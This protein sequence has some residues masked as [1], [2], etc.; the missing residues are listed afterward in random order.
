[1]F[2]NIKKPVVLGVAASLALGI[3]AVAPAA[4]A[5]PVSPSYVAV[6][7]DTL[8]ASM[9]AL[10]NGSNATGSTVR[11]KANGSAI[12]NFDAFGSAK[13][14]TKSTGPFFVRPAGSGNGVN[15]LIA[16]IRGTGFNG[17]DITGQVDIARSSSSA[18]ANA[19]ANGNLVYVPYGRDAITYV[20]KPVAGHEAD[21]ASLTTAQL[22]GLYNGT[23]TMIGSTTVNVMIPQSGSGT[24]KTWLA[25]LGVST[26]GTCSLAVCTSSTTP[27]NDASQ[28]TVAGSII[29]F[30]TS[31]WI[32]QANGYQT[33]TITGGQLLGTIDGNAAATGTAG[34]L[35]PGTAFYG[36]SYGRDTFLV[37]EYARVNPADPK[38]DA[39]LAGLVGSSLTAS[40]TSFGTLPNQSGAVK[41][42][43]GFLAP[44]STTPVRAYAW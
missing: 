1:M 44:S 21:L 8:E 5:D 10:T 34:N 24:R 3:F 9:N 20:Y 13:I 23:I 27:E 42:K 35:V 15:A 7:S 30:A 16:S 28:L 6:G 36:T 32:A 2:E 33:T 17:T 11:V 40:L 41:K 18:G 25:D 19:N 14:Q 37:V 38:Y 31:N 22:A 26:D 39:T 4:H 43:F 29:P 12:G